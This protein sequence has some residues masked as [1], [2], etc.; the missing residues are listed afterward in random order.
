MGW[1]LNSNGWLAVEIGIVL[2]FFL[3]SAFPNE[4]ANAERCH[5]TTIA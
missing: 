3:A 5:E 1:W 4:Q 2:W